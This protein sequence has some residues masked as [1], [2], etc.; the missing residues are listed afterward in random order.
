[1]ATGDY[2]ITTAP[3]GIPLKIIAR[4]PYQQ[5]YSWRQAID[6]MA[7]VD[8][9]TLYLTRSFRFGKKIAQAASTVL[10]TFFGETR[11]VLGSD[12]PAAIV[13]RLEADKL[14]YVCRTN[15]TIFEQGAFAAQQ[16]KRSRWRPGILNS[17]WKRSWTF[18]SST[19]ARQRRFG[20]SELPGSATLRPCWNLLP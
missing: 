4:D 16:G 8:A 5:I 10:R 12:K 19:R 7:V 3:A 14:T 18:T 6:A 9:P 17:S 13:P 2:W 11:P 1:M 15:A 20:T